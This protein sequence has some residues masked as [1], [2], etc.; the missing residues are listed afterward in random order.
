MDHPKRYNILFILP[1]LLCLCLTLTTIL[2]VYTLA[3]QN[4]SHREALSQALEV[5]SNQ[6]ETLQSVV[7][8]SESPST[9]IP[10]NTYED[11]NFFCLKSVN[12]RVGVYTAEGDLIRLTDIEISTLPDQ[13]RRSLEQG[14]YTSSWKEILHLLQDFGA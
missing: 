5:L 14:I 2:T 10:V 11:T 7:D 1:T 4:Q 9:D 12:G 13:E 3:K 6:M 8:G